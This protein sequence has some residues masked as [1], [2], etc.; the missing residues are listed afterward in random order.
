MYQDLICL[1]VGGITV[2]QLPRSETR[3][4]RSHFLSLAVA[5]EMYDFPKRA[6]AQIP[7]SQIKIRPRFF[8]RS[9]KD[10]SRP[11]SLTSLCHVIICLIKNKTYVF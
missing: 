8:F 11:P 4:T 10:F 2:N 5:R 1:A 7:T 3:A 6:F 9:R